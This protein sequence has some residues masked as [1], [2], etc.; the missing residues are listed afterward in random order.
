M[1]LHVQAQ[2][3]DTSGPDSSG[4]SSLTVAPTTS[5]RPVVEHP[6]GVGHRSPGNRCVLAIGLGDSQI[7]GRHRAVGIGCRVVAGDG[8]AH[9][10][11]SV[12]VAVLA[13]FVVRP[14]STSHT[15]SK[16][17]VAPRA[18][19]TVS[20]MSPVAGPAVQAEPPALLRKVPPPSVP[21]SRTLDG[22][23]P[24]RHRGRRYPSVHR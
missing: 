22:S 18:R 16:I 6:Y 10:I 23:E 3:P 1:V 2:P 4:K 17:S 7:R 12:T 19:L 24:P 5:P 11:G 13:R 8:I 15:A 20:V 14:G 9:T 21:A